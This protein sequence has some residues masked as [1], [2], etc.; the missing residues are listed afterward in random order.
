MQ[1]LINKGFSKG[2]LSINDSVTHGTR[3][4][5]ESINLG[6]SDEEK[7]IDLGIGMLD[8]PTDI[9]IDN[10]VI[11]TIINKPDIIHQFAPVKGF[12]VLLEAISKRVELINGVKYD[13]ESEIMVTPGGIKGA[14]SVVLN[15][16]LDYND[17]VIV[18]IPNWPHYADMIKLNNGIPV[19]VK[20]KDFINSG[21]SPD[22]LSLAIT[23]KT[24]LIL[25]GDCVNP[26][27]KVYSN[28]E[29]LKLADII[30]KYNLERAQKNLGPIY[31]LYDCPYEA[32]ILSNRS[33]ALASITI[34]KYSLRNCVIHVTGPGKTFGMHGDRIGYI[35]AYPLFIQV[36]ANVQVNMTSFAS[37]YGQIACLHALQDHM[38]EVAE[39]RAKIARNNLLHMIGLLHDFGLSV[40]TPEGGYFIFVNFLVYAT[41]YVACG[42]ETAEKFLLH[43]AK[44]ATISG[45]HFA[46]GY[47]YA[48]EFKHY[49]RINCGR[50]LDV[51]NNAALR[52]KNALSQL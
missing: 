17:E 4:L 48:D 11:N 8:I 10:G 29:L 24:K 15:T 43:S 33:L 46:K 25:L 27:G 35:C 5:I 30:A 16:L 12:S 13:P 45:T 20:C 38:R 49:V 21:I 39:R 47:E 51:L 52:I 23:N 3:Q 26:T 9:R 1:N 32:H 34:D 40:H 42:Y 37:T 50:D 22:D 44:V 2:A 28:E 36:A 31:V 41:K 18:P 6:K 7:I 14:I 19:F